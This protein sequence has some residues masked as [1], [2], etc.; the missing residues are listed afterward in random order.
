MMRAGETA[1]VIIYL[2][3]LIAAGVYFR[4]RAAR[5]TDDY[6]VAGRQLP[7]YVTC[8]GLLALATSGSM[9]IGGP[10][11]VYK[12]G[13]SMGWGMTWGAAFG[14]VG[15]AILIAMPLR[16]SGVVSIGE[17]MN[18]RYNH[19]LT[20][21]LFS[22][23]LL[24]GLLGYIIGNLK[25]ATLGFVYLSG[26]SYVVALTVVMIVF[27]LYILLGGMWAAGWIDLV[28]GS[29]ILL[30]LA[31]MA[32][33][34]LMY[35][36]GFNTLVV[37]SALEIPRI[38]GINFPYISYV[39]AFAN[40][41]IAFAILPH[42]VMRVLST[43]TNKGSRWALNM[44]ALLFMGFTVFF[45]LIVGTAGIRLDPTLKDADYVFYNLL[46][47]VVGSPFLRG[48]IMSCVFA[49]I[50]S[51][52]AGLLL[53]T[54]AI[55]SN[56][57]YHKWIRPNAS[58]RE[59]VLVGRIG[60][61]AC[62]LICWVLSVNPP[63]LVTV[64]IMYGI[65]IMG[66]GLFFPIVLGIW[67]KRPNAAG[68]VAGIVSGTLVYLYFQLFTKVAMF[69]PVIYGLAVSLV[70]TVAVS[71]LTAPGDVS[72]SGRNAAGPPT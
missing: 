50:I 55:L 58:Q 31:V 20:K 72:R 14:L 16:N 62:A 69:S 17:F 38:A 19:P 46:A 52:V 4:S 9:I 12:M 27:T 28:Q 7:A 11:I 48:I 13:W 54:A 56:D 6:W 35:F 15:A 10:G 1:V 57:I 63:Q 45:C 64:A 61:L 23:L 36:G 71:L 65:A 41:F 22:L 43:K 44:T 33:A 24:V 40:W 26:V 47:H 53:S 49:A 8:L 34:S 29:M 37:K 5:S 60:V 51:T 18:R 68:A 2:A 3:L 66:C 67:W 59:M 39:G 32:P 30:L 25:A 42:L 21:L 70:F